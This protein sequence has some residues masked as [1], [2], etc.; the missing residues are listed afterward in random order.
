M[1]FP[2]LLDRGECFIH[3][4]ACDEAPR[5]KVF[6]GGNEDNN[7][8]DA[9]TPLLIA[10][11]PPA[12]LEVAAIAL[13]GSALSGDTIHVAW[14]VHNIGVNQA[15]GTWTDAVYLS[16]APVFDT[17]TATFLTSAPNQKALPAGSSY[18]TTLTNVPLP[19]LSP[20]NYNVFFVANHDF[21]AYH[22]SFASQPESDPSDNIAVAALTLTAPDVHLQVSSPTVAD[23][24]PDAGESVNVSFV[25]SNSGSA[26]AAS[27]K[28][29]RGMNPPRNP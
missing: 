14:T 29:T 20:G 3:I 11:P 28:S 4:R 22:S 27:T 9:P 15:S 24:S 25:V 7:S 1:L 23:P 26:T 10:N 17:S 18:T 6:E 16:Q 8:L 13:P 5:G 19:Q 12:D 21:A 2:Q